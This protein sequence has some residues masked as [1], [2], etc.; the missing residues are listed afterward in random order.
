MCKSLIPVAI[1]AALRI[2]QDDR[3]F[4]QATPTTTIKG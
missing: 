2:G 4:A 1:A 3:A